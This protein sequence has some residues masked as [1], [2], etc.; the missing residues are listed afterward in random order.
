MPFIGH[1]AREKSSCTRRFT[2]ASPSV[3]MH[4]MFFEH[5]SEPLLPRH[6]WLK[7]VYRSVWLAAYIV[8]SVLAIG[9]VGY[10]VLGHLPWIDALLEASMIL[11]GMGAIAPMANDAVKLFASF[12]ALLSGLVVISV[13]A[14]IIA[15][16]LHRLLH[17]HTRA[18][19]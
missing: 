16:W 2:L 19:K 15:P 4:A 17:T 6:Q 5:S 11:G 3:R 13:T 10:H 9:I 1:A 14:I 12:Y 7:R 18:K 8:L